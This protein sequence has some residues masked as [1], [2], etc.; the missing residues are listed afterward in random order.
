MDTPFH[1]WWLIFS[2][3]FFLSLPYQCPYDVSLVT[4]GGGL[5]VNIEVPSVG[6]NWPSAVMEHQKDVV[7]AARIQAKIDCDTS[8][9]TV[10]EV[11]LEAGIRL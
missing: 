2:S 6:A 10:D 1:F 8:K 9:H 11:P 5:N 3:I 7:E 4:R